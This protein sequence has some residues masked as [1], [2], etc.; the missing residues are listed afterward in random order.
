LAA[1]LAVQGLLSASWAGPPPS[2]LLVAAE[3]LTDPNF[4]RTVVLVIQTP[5]GPLGF[6]L[7]R[8]SPVTVG[9]VLPGAPP[10]IAGSAVYV[11]GPVERGKVGALFSSKEPPPRA[12]QVLDE[13]YFSSSQA[14]ITALLSAAEAPKRLRFL[15]GYSGWAPGQLEAEL[16]RG[17]WW[18]WPADEAVVFD[19]PAEELWAL[20]YARATARRARSA[21][22]EPGS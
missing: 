3:H 22:S 4:H 14:T 21:A 20:L 9:D 7:N 11:G 13:L 1:L 18:V 2:L 15:A 5:R 19:T 16:E 12:L 8:P 17:D 6:V 10:P